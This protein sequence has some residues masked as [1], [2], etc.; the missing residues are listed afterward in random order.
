M[1]EKRTWFEMLKNIKKVE[2]KIDDFN[3]K[4]FWNEYF[5]PSFDESEIDSVYNEI[6]EKKWITKEQDKKFVALISAYSTS[7]FEEFFPCWG[8]SRKIFREFKWSSL[9]KDESLNNRTVYRWINLKK[10]AENIEF[11]NKMKKNWFYIINPWHESIKSFSY[12]KETAIEFAKTGSFDFWNNCNLKNKIKYD[13]LP[14][15]IWILLKVEINKEKDKYLF[16]WKSIWW[17]SWES[18][19]AFYFDIGDKIEIESIYE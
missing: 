15:T 4:K 19:V 14:W 1:S 10:T 6:I 17:Y 8:E 16:D 5:W 18:E 12:D 7:M 13:L 9:F 3:L 11:V 2:I